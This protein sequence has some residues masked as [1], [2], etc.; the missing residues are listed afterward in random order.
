[1]KSVGWWNEMA[2]FDG[3]VCGKE[4]DRGGMPAKEMATEWSCETVKYH[5]RLLDKDRRLGAN[6]TATHLVD[7]Q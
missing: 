4:A 3:A 7:L 1:M 2:R 5:R 6:E